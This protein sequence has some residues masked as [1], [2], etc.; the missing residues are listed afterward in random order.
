MSNSPSKVNSGPPI[1]LWLI[2]VPLTLAVIGGVIFSSIPPNLDDAYEAAVEAIQDPNGQ[3]AFDKKLALLETDPAY[4]EHVSLLKGQVAMN[5]NRDPMALKLFAEI[6]KGSPLKAEADRRSGDAYRRMGEF[7]EAVDAYRQALERESGNGLEAR[8]NLASLYFSAGA[9]ELARIELDHN[10]E[11]DPSHE[12]SRIL[13]AR[14][15]IFRDEHE[16]AREDFEQVLNSPGKY[17]SS[18]PEFVTEYFKCLVSLKDVEKLREVAQSH[19][20]TIEDSTVRSS[21]LSEIG[22]YREA[23]V[24]LQAMAGPETQSGTYKA[25]QLKLLLAEGNYDEAKLL[26]KEIVGLIPRDIPTMRLVA[27]AFEAGGETR[28]QKIAEENLDQLLDLKSQLREAI[29]QVSDNITDGP[30]RAKVA[31]LYAQL[32]D[33]PQMD[34][35]YNVAAMLDDSLTPEYMEARSGEGIPTTPLVSFDEPA[36]EKTEDEASEDKTKTEDPKS[37]PTEAE[38]S[39]AVK[40]SEDVAAAGDSDTSAKAGNS[41]SKKSDDTAKEAENEKDAGKATAEQEAAADEAAEKKTNKPDRKT[42]DTTKLP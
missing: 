12:S 21:V 35:W 22:E 15:R 8:M 11:I 41:D 6:P 17:S 32:T 25:A 33:Y 42:D 9:M 26:A 19:L 7:N 36:A 14:L 2:L 39:A 10:I 16:L 34:S 27:K 30:G 24:A 31:R 38:D 29:D 13:R 20:G 18:S 5:Q 37:D 23:M 1:W 28:M 4:T 40:E 3:D